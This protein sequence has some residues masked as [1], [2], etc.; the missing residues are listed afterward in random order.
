MNGC[1]FLKLSTDNPQ[2]TTDLP[3]LKATAGRQLRTPQSTTFN[4]N[5][6]NEPQTP[7]A[8]TPQ[9]VADEEIDLLALAKTLW[10][11][12]KTLIISI[13]SGIILGVFIALLSPKEYTAS[14]VMVP[15]LGSDSQSKLGGLG[16]LAALAGI[17][18]DMN[19][20][21]ELS[22]MVYP[23]IVASIPFQLEL[24]NTPLSFQKFPQPVSLF[25]YYTKYNNPSAFETI[26]K[27]TIGLPFVI[28][29]AIKGKPN[30]VRLSGNLSNQ[31]VVLTEDQYK[32]KKIIEKLVSLEV[33]AKEGYLTLTTRMS[34]PLAT[35]QLAQNAQQML[36]RYITEFKIEKAKAN[37]DF[38][39]Q[40]YI[41]TKAEFEKTQVSL[42]TNT[43]RNRDFTS[44]LSKIETDRIQTRYTISFNVFQELAKQLE[45]A[46]I[47]VKKETPVFTIV[48]P[49]TVPTEKTKP[50]KVMIV[51]IW[52]FLGGVI[53]CVIVFGK[54]YVAT[55]KQKWNDIPEEESTEKKEKVTVKTDTSAHQE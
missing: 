32:I 29:K 20:G 21:A 1:R 15:Q 26:K 39:Q 42:A 36:Q 44:G 5:T 24:M 16:G 46:K 37:L 49:V 35:A 40:R 54:G 13:V 18:L 17:S 4:F 8:T 28:L 6:M 38:I 27:Y 41:E 45:Q 47:Q 10:N 12:R 25:D 31:P 53:G 14:T 7:I 48:Q 11:G 30:E 33:N 19:T 52:L 23:Q 22:P 55:L 9:A 43:D 34:E 3:P 2:R 50:K 51:A